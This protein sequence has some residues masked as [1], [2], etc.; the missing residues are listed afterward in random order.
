MWSR[1]LPSELVIAKM[2]YDANNCD[3]HNWSH[4]LECYDFLEKNHISY[5]ADL[6]IAILFHDIVYD[7]LPE[8]EVRSADLM[9]SLYPQTDSSIY[10][11][12]KATQGHSIKNCDWKTVAMIKADLHA[13]LSP[14]K[15]V[16]NYGK[17][18]RESIKLYD[19]DTETFIMKNREFMLSLINTMN[20]NYRINLDEFWLKVIDGIKLSIAIGA[21]YTMKE[22]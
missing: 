9:M 6:D 1:Q 7:N 10:R 12:I 16:E 20:N 17:I 19:V 18:M 2:Y 15:I 21:N 11:I 5:S 22:K 8:K 13:F 4:I 3:Y 14:M